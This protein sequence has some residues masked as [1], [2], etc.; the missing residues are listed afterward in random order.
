MR[1]Q[2]TLPDRCEGNYRL[3]GLEQL[4]KGLEKLEKLRALESE[5]DIGL[6]F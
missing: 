3:L 4:G 6:S 2:V 5:R 1:H